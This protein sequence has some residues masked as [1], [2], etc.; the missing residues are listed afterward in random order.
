MIA[1]VV[2][3]SIMASL[4]LVPIFLALRLQRNDKD[5]VTQWKEV[6]MRE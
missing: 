1:Q 5:F 6:N 4:S 3:A 2:A